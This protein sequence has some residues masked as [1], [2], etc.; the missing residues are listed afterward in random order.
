[1]VDAGETIVTEIVLFPLRQKGEEVVK[2][3]VQANDDESQDV[4]L[5]NPDDEETVLSKLEGKS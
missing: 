2:E 4:V 5:D 1:M 3:N